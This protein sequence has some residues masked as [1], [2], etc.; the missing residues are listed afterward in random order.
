MKKLLLTGLLSLAMATAAHA[1]SFGY[2]STV[3]SS[4]VFDGASHFTFGPAVNNFQ[5]GSGTAA[6]LFGEITGSFTIGTVV[7]A[8][9][10]VTGTGT[11]VIHDGANTLTATLV[12]QNIAQLGTLDGL[13]TVGS[14]N[15]TAITYGGSNADLLKL[16]NSITGLNTLSFQFGSATTVNTLKT[17]STSTTF[18]GTVATPDGGT[19]VVL[20]GFALAGMGTLRRTIKGFRA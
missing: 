6:G 11:F 1:M 12:W 18:S 3:G 2:A 10:P 13:N 16:K 14:A 9:A 19:T 20:L 15:L 4:I 5:V 8:S 7:S 17:T